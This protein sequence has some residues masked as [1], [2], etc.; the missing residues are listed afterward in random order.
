MS[1]IGKRVEFLLFPLDEEEKEIKFKSEKSLRGVFNQYADNA[2]L[3]L[4]N[5]AWQNHVI[6]KFKQND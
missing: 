3:A 5:T 4:E 6:G 1:Y 2:K